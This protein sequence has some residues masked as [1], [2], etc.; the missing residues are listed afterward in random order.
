MFL[1]NPNCIIVWHLNETEQLNIPG[2][3][4][5][6]RTGVI[7]VMHEAMA[8]GFSYDD[9]HW[10]NL[11]QG[12]PETGPLRAGGPAPAPSPAGGRI[13]R[14]RRQIGPISLPRL[15]HG[16]VETQKHKRGEPEDSPL[17]S[18]AATA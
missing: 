14:V 8:Q 13:V 11:G 10:A 16:V 3:R 7:Y 4:F 6:P 5:V 17:L 2:F 15:R 12:S 1:L 18:S 9:P